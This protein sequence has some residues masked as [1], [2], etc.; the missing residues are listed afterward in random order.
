M[1]AQYFAADER[2]GFPTLNAAGVPLGAD[3]DARRGPSLSSMMRFVRNELAQ[4]PKVRGP[5]FHPSRDQFLRRSSIKLKI[6]Y[7]ESWHLC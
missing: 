3:V 7:P 6:Q 1:R 4:R 2:F 5:G